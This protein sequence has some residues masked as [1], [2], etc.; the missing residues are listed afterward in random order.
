MTREEILEA[1]SQ[2]AFEMIKT[3]QLERSGIRDG[4]G[5]WHGADVI[6]HMTSNMTTLCQALDGE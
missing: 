4:D 1:L 2:A 3:I 6:S 5:Y